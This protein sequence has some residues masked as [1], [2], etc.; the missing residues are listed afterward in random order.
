[1]SEPI[2]ARIPKLIR[3]CRLNQTSTDAVLLMPEGALKIK[4]SGKDVIELCNGTLSV[5]EILAQLKKRYPQVKATQIEIEAIEFLKL[6]REKRAV[7]F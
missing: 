7:D 6:L 2:H 4:G 3:N 1:M 5:Q